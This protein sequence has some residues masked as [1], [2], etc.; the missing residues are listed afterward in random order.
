MPYAYADQLDGSVKEPNI[1]HNSESEKSTRKVYEQ[2]FENY[3][4]R[5]RYF[6][7]EVSSFCTRRIFFKQNIMFNYL[8]IYYYYSKILKKK[9]HINAFYFVSYLQRQLVDKFP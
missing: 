6:A 7:L 8:N 4:A 5:L 3:S 2:L 1:F 9:K